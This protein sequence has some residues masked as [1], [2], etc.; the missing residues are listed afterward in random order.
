MNDPDADKQSTE[1]NGKP[2]LWMMNSVLSSV[3][4]QIRFA[5]TKGGF[6][7]SV[8]ALFFGLLIARADKLAAVATKD[9]HWIFYTAIALLV[10]YTIGTFVSVSHVIFSIM[11]RVKKS[12][13]KGRT[14][15]AHIREGFMEDAEKYRMEVKSMTDSD[16]ADDLAQQIVDVCEIAAV[17]HALIYRASISS[18]FSFLLWVAAMAFT[19]L[20]L[21]IT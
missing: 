19:A 4:E 14:F 18:L 20:S 15:F 6:I 12:P 21:H 9:R 1:K 5:D 7:A 8:S 11:P 10:I 3:Q 16:W 13:G 17:K 2:N